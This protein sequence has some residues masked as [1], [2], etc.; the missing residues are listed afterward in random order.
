MTENS[1]Y[2]DEPAEQISE[3]AATTTTARSGPRRPRRGRIVPAVLPVVLAIG[4]GGLCS[5][6]VDAGLLPAAFWPGSI[7][8]TAAVV[9]GGL[10]V[11]A[12]LVVAVARY[13]PS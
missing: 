7:S 8:G 4:I 12:V 11:V 10:L 5:L 3:Q 6:V 13:D 1:E 2:A 9:G